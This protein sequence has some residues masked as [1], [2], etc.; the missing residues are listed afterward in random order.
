[1]KSKTIES[2]NTSPEVNNWLIWFDKHI[3]NHL[4]CVAFDELLLERIL[5]NNNNNN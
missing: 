2:G 3:K 5:K 4:E 1:M